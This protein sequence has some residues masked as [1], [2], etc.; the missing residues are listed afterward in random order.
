MRLQ[1]SD[2]SLADLQRV[3]AFLEPKSRRAAAQAV[4]NIR[5]GARKLLA[6]PKLGERLDEYPEETRRLLVGDYE[7]RYRPMLNTIYVVR[8]FHMREER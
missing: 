7:L 1:W 2:S 3:Q 4:A 8:I 5:M 6:H